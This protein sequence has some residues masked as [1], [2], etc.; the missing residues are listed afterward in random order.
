MKWSRS[1]RIEHG[2][3]VMIVWRISKLKWAA[4]VFPV[5]GCRESA[6]NS[7]GHKAVYCGET[8]ALAAWVLPIP[9]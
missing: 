8:R 2:V 5:L 4:S 6:L 1:G 7:G 3:F 9:R